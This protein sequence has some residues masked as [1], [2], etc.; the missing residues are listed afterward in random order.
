MLV[1]RLSAKQIVRWH[2]IT[3]DQ[4]LNRHWPIRLHYTLRQVSTTSITCLM[5]CL[6]IDITSVDVPR[7]MNM[8]FIKRS[9][10]C[11]IAFVQFWAFS[12]L[13]IFHVPA[14]VNTASGCASVCSSSS[15][16]GVT[17][18]LYSWATSGWRLHHSLFRNWCASHCSLCYFKRLLKSER[19]WPNWSGWM[20]PRLTNGIAGDA[21]DIKS[22]AW[23]WLS[24]SNDRRKYLWPDRR[25]LT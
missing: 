6:V 20:V 16:E 19:R 9:L 18:S 11:E 8:T 25:K 4:L 3:L 2:S 24:V 13:Y 10:A 14:K 7:I 17:I 1:D 12:F 15:S 22:C 23:L 5:S 21:N